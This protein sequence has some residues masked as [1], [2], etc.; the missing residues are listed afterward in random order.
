[1]FTLNNPM[2]VMNERYAVTSNPCPFCDKTKTVTVSSDQL[3]A[4]NQGSMVQH[5]LEDYSAGIRERF[6]SG[7]CEECW[8]DF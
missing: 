6:L 3:Y 2:K 4:Y 1:M 5:V 7:I 8:I